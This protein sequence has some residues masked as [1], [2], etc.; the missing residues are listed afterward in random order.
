MHCED[1]IEYMSQSLDGC[2]DAEQEQ[3]LQ[4]HL[5]GCSNCTE[6]FEA[7]KQT[8]ALLHGEEPVSAPGDLAARVREALDSKPI[9]LIGWNVF[10]HP[11]VAVAL[12]A[13]LVIMVGIYAVVRFPEEAGLKSEVAIQRSLKPAAS[14]EAYEGEDKGD[15]EGVGAEHDV[16][17]DVIEEIQDVSHAPGASACA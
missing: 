17:I 15:V 14:K 2:L 4:A 3:L 16:A 5:G 7:L 1:I 6:Q 10:N 11:Q 13:G 12:A 8:V 9:P